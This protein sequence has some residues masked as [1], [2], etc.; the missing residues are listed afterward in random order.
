MALPTEE[1]RA[2]A[3]GSAHVKWHPPGTESSAN[4]ETRCYTRGR[5]AFCLFIL[6]GLTYTFLYQIFQSA[7][8][9]GHS[10][11]IFKVYS[12]SRLLLFPWQLFPKATTPN[13]SEN[14]ITEFAPSTQILL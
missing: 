6:L 1:S 4:A 11:N 10:K 12:S 7:A 2:M 14:V 13:S 5:D 9:R 3:G 8:E